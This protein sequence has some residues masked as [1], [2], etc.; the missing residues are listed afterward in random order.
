[1]RTPEITYGRGRVSFDYDLIGHAERVT[2]KT[3][4]QKNG[5]HQERFFGRGHE[6][7]RLNDNAVVRPRK[8]TLF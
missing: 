7:S 2:N 3:S 1:M 8:E 4:D 6:L 5:Q